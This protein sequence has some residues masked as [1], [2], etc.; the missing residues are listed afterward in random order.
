MFTTSPDLFC[1][2]YVRYPKLI[3]TAI[4]GGECCYYFQRT[5]EETKAIKD[6]KNQS[7]TSELAIGRHGNRTPAVL[8]LTSKADLYNRF[9]KHILVREGTNK[10]I[11]KSIKIFPQLPMICRINDS[12]MANTVW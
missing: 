7:M 4:L 3:F 1:M 2:L 6:L 10:G 11:K 5:I 9:A 8:L 12:L